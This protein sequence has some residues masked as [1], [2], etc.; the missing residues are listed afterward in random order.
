MTRRGFLGVSGI[1]AAGNTVPAQDTEGDWFDRPMRWAQL[2]FVENDPGRYDLQFWLDYM[3][4]IHADAAC[5]S[6]GGC[7]AF[8]P[9]KVPFHHRGKFQGDSDPF[10]DLVAG[11]RKMNMVVVA[12]TD[13]HATYDD[14]A[15]A[16]PDWIAVDAQGRP[17]R[18][19]ASPEMWVTCAL[20]PYNFE[21]MTDVTREIVSLY[22]VDGVFS[23]RWAGHGQCWCVHCRKNFRDFSGMDLPRTADPREPARKQYILWH[24]KRLFDLWR[25]WD[26]E[27][28]KVNP[29]AR[30]IANSGG[31]ALSDLDMK[32]VG[33]LSATLAADRQARRGVMPPWAAGKN[34]KEYRATLGRKPV[35]GITSVGLEEPYRWKDSVQSPEEIKL[36][37]ADGV[38][39]G[40][41]P[42]FTKFA[43]HL[44][45][46]R[47]LKPVEEFYGWHWRNERYLRNEEPL[48][49][50]AMVYSQ[51]T[52][53][54]YG[55]ERARQ[56]VEDH[57]L[58]LYHALVE[59]RIPF[60]MV[61]DGL[62]D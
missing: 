33:E 7:V 41:R 2:A 16:H 29:G 44:Y 4:R 62:L 51:Q 36:W 45:D 61:H 56:K 21:F 28:R 35:M 24:Q 26:A 32:T 15:A 34:A 58:G 31:G 17:R 57:T 48:A 38:A 27:I 11:C 53:T 14:A 52:A 8:Y 12:R 23:N 19:W 46:R 59:A 25:L 49:R 9:T 5:L 47:W 40:F 50:V 37:L 42:W 10:G 20:G 39:N 18:H 43:L 54:F 55:G 13:P 30:Y 6:A 1:A 3:R 22:K 60:E